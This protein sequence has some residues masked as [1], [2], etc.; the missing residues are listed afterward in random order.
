MFLQFHLLTAFPPHNVN[1][2][3]DGRPK[4]VA[5][6]GA[7]RGRI[8]SQAKKR[9][10]RYAPHFA[11]LQRSV[12]T[13]EA[14]IEA[15]QKLRKVGTPLIDAAFVALAVNFAIGG[16]DKAPERK[17][18]AEVVEPGTNAKGR[19]QA[20]ARAKEKRKNEIEARRR[21]T[22][23]D[24]TAATERVIEEAVGT[25]QGLVISTR[26][27]ANL[28][29]QIGHLAD[30]IK[31]SRSGGIS[32]IVDRFVAR[33]IK[34]GL[35]TRDAIDEDTALFGRM[36]A[37]KPKFNVEAAAAVSHAL[38]TH[39]FAVEG[40]YFSAGE[41]LNV[42]GGTGAAITSYG[43]LGSG[44]YYQYAVL[45]VVHLRESLGGD[46]DRTVKAVDTLLEGL[47]HAQPTGKRNAFGSDVAAGFVLCDRGTAPATN[48]AAAF[49]RPVRVGDEAEDLMLAS[50]RR[51]RDFHGTLK[52]AYAL[53]TAS[54]AFVAHHTARVGNDPPAGEVWTFAELREFARAAIT[55]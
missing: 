6:G 26:E 44:V 22:G 29:E 50:I 13:R 45:D 35:L 19:D 17:D 51:L 40:D 47:V 31:S 27:L 20:A 5:F 33:L 11:G 1:R 28:C 12:R 14:G 43:F 54:C 37:A 42:L 2:D 25:E 8:S 7:L 16:G 39:A 46:R 41:E 48:L 4:T 24:E 15:F 9:A 30:E 10:L 36:V 32:A 53:P 21:K 49:L 38:T 18:A 55:A 23:E 52:R 34:D 3:E